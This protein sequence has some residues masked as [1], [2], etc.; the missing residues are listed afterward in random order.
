MQFIKELEEL[1]F[2]T[3]LKQLTERLN[4]DAA[5]IYKHL[6]IRFEPRWF[7]FF[8]LL[9]KRAPLTITEIS[10]QLGFSQPA[11]TQLADILIKEGLIKN[12]KDTDTRKR[13]LTLS[14][15]G[16]RMIPLL[17]PVWDGFESATKDLFKETGIDVLLVL[18]KLEKVLDAKSLSE[19]IAD[20]V[21]KKQ[22]ESIEI[23]KF[24]TGHKHYFRDLN[25]EWLTKFFSIEE[26]DRQM[27][28]NPEQE[29]LN[30]GGE[31][32]FAKHNNEIMGTAALIQHPNNIY[33]LA[34]MAVSEKSQGRQ[35]GKMLA[36]AVIEIAKSKK[37]KKI[38]L[39]TNKKLTA[40]YNLYTKLGFEQVSYPEGE[41]SKY[42]RSTIK[43]ELGL[44]N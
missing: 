11:A 34:K 43:M 3:R 12:V 18:D 23:I 24:N 16:K 8:Y 36:L 4:T 1:A 13:L 29:I 40:A 41:K 35:V 42:H 26:D 5:K 20:K 22:S 39:E 44:N 31:I 9:Y 32:I 30:K 33:E 14:E 25:Y 19:R 2:G 6:S 15:K 7:T 21:K 38:F 27:L 17:Q 10:A 37:A 28:E